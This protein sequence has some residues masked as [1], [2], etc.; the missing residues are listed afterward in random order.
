M[1]E[2]CAQ[3]RLSVIQ[4]KIPRVFVNTDPEVTFCIWMQFWC[5]EVCEFCA[6]SNFLFLEKF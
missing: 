5:Q 3:V 6:Y 4:R 1:E 2:M